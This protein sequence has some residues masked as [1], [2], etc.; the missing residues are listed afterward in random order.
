MTVT[1]ERQRRRLLRA[2]VALVAGLT[3]SSCGLTE[4][5]PLDP[6]TAPDV[7]TVSALPLG[8][9]GAPREVL[10]VGGPNIHQTAKG[11]AAAVTSAPWIKINNEAN[12]DVRVEPIAETHARWAAALERFDPDVVVAQMLFDMPTLDC[13]GT[14]VE[15]AACETEGVRVWFEFQLA[16]VREHLTATGAHLIWVTYPPMAH[17]PDPAARAALAENIAYVNEIAADFASAHADVTVVDGWAPLA[18]DGEYASYLPERGAAWRQARQPDGVRICPHGA[19]L[20][21]DAVAEAL[22]PEW[23]G[24][25]D[26]DWVEGAWRSD[27]VFYVP[28]RDIGDVTLCDDSRATERAYVE[29]LSPSQPGLDPDAANRG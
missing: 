17:D 15:I 1:I 22:V 7:S 8:N 4:P 29:H 3:L 21:A 24:G 11:L 25:L 6:V 2:T 13:T 20:V 9:T 23:R 14:D 26:Q 27:D 12:V 18:L 28:Q 16:E 19:A 10:V 5:E